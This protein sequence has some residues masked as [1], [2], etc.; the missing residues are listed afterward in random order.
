MTVEVSPDAVLT[1]RTMLRA[2]MQSG[3]WAEVQ[4]AYRLLGGEAAPFGVQKLPVGLRCEACAEVI[5]DGLAG[6]GA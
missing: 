6:R 2:A 3:R 1:A 4:R 5:E